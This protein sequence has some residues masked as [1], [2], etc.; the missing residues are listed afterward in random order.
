MEE[1]KER[2]AKELA[3]GTF[4]SEPFI[5][6]IAFICSVAIYID[7]LKPEGFVNLSTEYLNELLLEHGYLGVFGFN[8]LYLMQAT[9]LY[10]LWVCYRRKVADNTTMIT[11]TIVTVQE[12]IAWA[13]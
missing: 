1:L 10:S 13:F 2:R 7:S 8:V 11:A 4:W 6:F 12:S 5:Y 9:A 3:E